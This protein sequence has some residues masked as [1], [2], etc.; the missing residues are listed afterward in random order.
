M[1]EFILQHYSF[2]CIFYNFFISND[3]SKDISMMKKNGK[4]RSVFCIPFQAYSFL[5][6]CKHTHTILS[7]LLITCS[8]HFFTKKQNSHTRA[9]KNS[10]KNSRLPIAY[11]LGRNNL[12]VT[13]DGLIFHC[14]NYQVIQAVG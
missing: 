4:H 2:H 14:A 8:F 12:K 1:N 11:C 7:G 6:M 13:P 5:I 3:G 10:P 9:G